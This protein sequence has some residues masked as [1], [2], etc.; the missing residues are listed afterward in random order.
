M[1]YSEYAIRT[2]SVTLTTL[3][4]LMALAALVVGSG[5]A[6]YRVSAWW[7]FGAACFPALL[8][9]AIAQREVE[10]RCGTGG[11]GG[12]PTWAFVAC[13]VSSL[14][15]YGAATVGGIVDGIRLGASQ[16]YGAAFLR[17]LV[18]PIASACGV[19]LVLYGFLGAVFH[20]FD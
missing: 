10:Q 13:V 17:G 19:A 12:L 11:V 6:Y 16:A 2:S 4:L 15:L 18:C 1:S 7:L 8:A 9:L 14:T 20:C 5:A 3:L